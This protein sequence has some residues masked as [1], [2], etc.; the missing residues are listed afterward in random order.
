M[1]TVN[2]EISTLRHLASS[3]SEISELGSDCWLFG[4]TGKKGV[5]GRDIDLLVLGLTHGNEV[6]GLPIIANIMK[7]LISQKTKLNVCLC[8]GNIQ[9]AVAGKRF[10]ESDLNRSFGLKSASN[11]E[12]ARAIFIGQI[13]EKSTWA[14]DLHQTQTKTTRPFFISRFDQCSYNLMRMLSDIQ[15]VTYF[16]ASFSSEGMTTINYHL[17]KGGSGF[18]I[19][20]GTKG[21][22][23]EQIT[24]GQN[25]VEN[26]LNKISTPIEVQF[27]VN[28]D[29]RSLMVKQIVSAKSNYL[30]RTDLANMSKLEEGEFIG[31]IDN[32]DVHTFDSCFVLFP[33]NG[34][35]EPIRI[36][37]VTE[38]VRLLQ[39]VGLVTKS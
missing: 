35:K 5:T 22:C 4:G 2:D 7:H 34:N 10:I 26:M 38:V 1:R 17:S 18:G 28:K 6:V 31:T 3:S 11:A 39:P 9:A 27:D 12:E 20:L 24:F 36:E 29:E 16:T 14:I 25:I 8:L 30:L 23:E 37:K 21:F 19:E 32:N 33:K 15:F 13:M